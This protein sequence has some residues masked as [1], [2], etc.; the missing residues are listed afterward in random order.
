MGFSIIS[1]SAFLLA[2]H[3]GTDKPAHLRSLISAFVIRY[4]KREVSLILHILVGF[5]IISLWLRHCR[6]P[7][8]RPFHQYLFL[9]SPGN[10][11]LHCFNNKLFVFCVP[12]IIPKVVFVFPFLNFSLAL[13]HRQNAIRDKL[14]RWRPAFISMFSGGQRQSICPKLYLLN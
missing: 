4:L 12:L 3:K 11:R 8:L 9:C 13:A 1:A 6:R 5:N 14:G 2:N 7:Y 10:D